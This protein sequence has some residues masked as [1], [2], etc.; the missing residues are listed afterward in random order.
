MDFAELGFAQAASCLDEGMEDR[1]QA[2]RAGDGGQHVADR[3]LLIE[4]PLDGIDQA[5]IGDRDRRLIG[6]RAE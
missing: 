2:L 6:E 1:L 3:P 5:R 4:L